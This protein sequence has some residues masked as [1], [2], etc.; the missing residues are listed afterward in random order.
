MHIDLHRGMPQRFPNGSRV[1]ISEVVGLL[2]SPYYENSDNGFWSDKFL[3][4]QSCGTVR[5]TGRIA[6]LSLCEG[7]SRVEYMASCLH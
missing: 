7:D 6:R 4:K 5:E 2:A 3:W 1:L